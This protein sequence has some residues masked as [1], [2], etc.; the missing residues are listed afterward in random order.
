MSCTAT[1][2]TCSPPVAACSTKPATAAGDYT[3]AVL[4]GPDGKSLARCG[5]KSSAFPA[6][7]IQDALFGKVGNCGAA[8]TPLLLVAALET[9]QPGDKL[10]AAFYGDG[11][12]ALAIDVLASGFTPH[13]SI[14]WYLA[15]GRAL[16]S[17]D[18]YL[19]SR[20]LDPGEHD[21]RG[22]EGVPATIHYRERDSDINFLG[23]RCT[24]CGTAAF[25]RLPRLL[26]LLCQR[27]V[28]GGAPVRQTGPRHELQL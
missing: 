11:A 6:D 20:H 15:R 27:P 4:G 9:A 8:F 17:Y 21:R 18:S 24:Q 10:L 14:A 23:Q 26:R 3:R 19:K 5:K 12:E 28:R 13:H 16:R 2:T 7:R 22:G 25:S 1:P